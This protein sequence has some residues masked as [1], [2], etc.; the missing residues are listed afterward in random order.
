MRARAIWRGAVLADSDDTVLVEGR[1]YF[2]RESLSEEYLSPSGTRTVCPWKGV[3]SYYSVTV[4]GETNPDA[5]W[6]YRKPFPTARRVKDRVAFWRGVE[7][8]TVADGESSRVS[9]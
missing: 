8:V 6:E 9:R 4:A 5:A 7:I 3:A 1:H 2:P